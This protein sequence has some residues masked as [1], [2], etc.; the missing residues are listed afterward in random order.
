MWWSC[1]VLWGVAKGNYLVSFTAWNWGY[2]PHAFVLYNWV[3]VQTGKHQL[4]LYQSLWLSIYLG[5]SS[6]MD[7]C[8]VCWEN[9]G[10]D[11]KSV[12]GC[13]V[14]LWFLLFLGSLTW[15]KAWVLLSVVVW[16]H[17]LIVG[18]SM[19][20]FIFFLYLCVIYMATLYVYIS[21]Y[22]ATKRRSVELKF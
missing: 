21:T 14:V 22:I 6:L 3:S 4:Y 15:G 11:R 12:P 17:R 2:K 7:L 5:L 10:K 19:F 1:V 16:G 13:Y 9:V 20:H 18:L 8:F